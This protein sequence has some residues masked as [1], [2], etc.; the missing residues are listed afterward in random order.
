MFVAVLCGERIGMYYLWLCCVVRE[1]ACTVFGCVVWSESW[2]V[3]LVAVLCG[4]RV[5]MYCLWLCCVVRELAC[6]VCGCVV[7]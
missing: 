5:G 4:E 7:W 3:L 1:L 2:H 6:T